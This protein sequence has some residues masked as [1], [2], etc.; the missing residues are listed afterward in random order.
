MNI[1]RFIADMLH[2]A[3]IVTL[4]Y[5][6]KVT[7]NCIGKSPSSILISTCESLE[8]WWITTQNSVSKISLPVPQ[9]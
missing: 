4:L 9:I 5:R 6:I 1:F 2:L 7:R 8:K 3:A